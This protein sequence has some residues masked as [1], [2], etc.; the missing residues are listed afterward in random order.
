[1]LF[2]APLAAQ[3]TDASRVTPRDLRPDTPI[4]TPILEQDVDRSPQLTGNVPENAATL[5]VT[6]AEVVVIDGFEAMAG[7]SSLMTDAFR[8]RRS[9][10]AEL[11]ALAAEL[12]ALYQQAGYVLTRVT[13]P[14]QE[15]VDGGVFH[16]QLV[17]GY[18]ESI[19]LDAVPERLRAGVSARL[20]GLVNRSQLRRADIERALILAGRSPGLYVRSTLVPGDET[21]AAVLVL[22][23]EYT[24]FSGSL[25]AD[26]RLSDALG[27][28]QS[29]MQLQSNQLLGRGEQFYAYVSGD[30][31]PTVSLRG[32]GVRQVFGGGI[33]WPLGNNGMSVNGEFTSSDTRFESGNTFI[34]DTR[35][36]FDRASVRIDLPVTVTRTGEVNLSGAFEMSKQV[37]DMPDFGLE[38]YRDVL[39]VIRV[40]ADAQYPLT[41]RSQLAL[42][43]QLSQGLKS[44]ARTAADVQSSGVPFSRPG[45]RPDF[46]KLEMSASWR[47]VMSGWSGF[48][49][50]VLDG[51]MFASTLRAQHALAGPLPSAEL[52]SLDGES[53]LSAL[54]SGGLAADDGWTLRNEIS[55]SF[56]L[57]NNRISLS[58][59]AYLSGG[60]PRSEFGDT[61]DYSLSPGLG[62]RA[63]G[64]PFSLD[65]EY[66]QNRI[67]PGGFANNEF[68][69]TMRVM[70]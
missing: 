58:P 20:Q 70:F 10:V 40:G 23:A 26:N 1:M 66:G 45:A 5:S 17:D 22:E 53:A 54:V 19:N 43:A 33:S 2:S 16:L 24:A 63:R 48:G 11:Y 68:F 32:D 34:P 55:Q 29:T 9:T 15:V 67:Y 6:V 28:W 39:R 31:D 12:E 46:T 30:P 36:R 14:P 60:A 7:A 56:A 38:L 21:G 13:V 49:G 42:F 25:S 35:S 52:F 18:L 44:G 59:Y 41:P 50:S 27:P 62:L 3:P 57:W 51:A 69:I 65:M 47:F 8:D 37:N 4:P 61:V 64:G